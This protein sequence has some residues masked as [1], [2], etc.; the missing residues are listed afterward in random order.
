MPFRVGATGSGEEERLCLTTGL[1]GTLSQR[2][3]WAGRAL[4]VSPSPVYGA[5]LL[6]GLR[7][8]PSRGFK[9][10]HL[11]PDQG[12]CRRGRSWPARRSD[13]LVSLLGHPSEGLR[14][15]H[16][17]HNTGGDLPADRV[18]HVVIS[19]RHRRAGPAQ[20][21]ITS[22]ERCERAGPGLRIKRSAVQ[23]F[24]PPVPTS[25]DDRAGLRTD[26]GESNQEQ[27][28]TAAWAWRCGIPVA[29]VLTPLSKPQGIRPAPP[30]SAQRWLCR[31]ARGRGY[32]S[33][34][35]PGA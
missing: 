33:R 23:G 14:G 30:T 7:A 32:P 3:A 17:R 25:A 12:E 13:T 9:S 28:S 16:R 1:L 2:S 15:T 21:D 4:E 22:H 19:S 34:R 6:S 24:G 18:R 11:R 29:H 8:Q 26:L 5:R 27:Q 10:R 35:H 20:N 31:R